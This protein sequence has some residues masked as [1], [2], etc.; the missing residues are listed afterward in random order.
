MKYLLALFIGLLAMP[1]MATDVIVRQRVV[2]F[3]PNTY[4]GLQGYYSHGQKLVAE[5]NA[6][7][8]EEL[9]ILREQVEELKKMTLALQ[10]LTLGNVAGKVPAKPVEP[11]QKPVDALEAKVLSLY[12]DKCAKCHGD[13]KQDGDL[14]LVK[15]GKLVISDNDS[16]EL[17]NRELVFHRTD[18]S[19]LLEGEARMPKGSAPLTDE[20]V[21]TLK[22]WM[23]SKALAIKSKN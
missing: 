11:E 22:L 19:L 15:D 9:K 13:T 5:D 4:L 17:A 3:D 6:K 12:L 8:D 21:K 20:E 16:L 1:V 10:S 23:H 2:Q 14:T 18:A 7:K